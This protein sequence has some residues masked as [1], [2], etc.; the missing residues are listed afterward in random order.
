[1]GGNIAFTDSTHVR[2]GLPPRSF[3]SFYAAAQEAAESRVYAGMHYWMAV[4]EG[5]EQGKCVAENILEKLQIKATAN[6]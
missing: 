3:A 4:S 2:I 1:L 6:N 5:M